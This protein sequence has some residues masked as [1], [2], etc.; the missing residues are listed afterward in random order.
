MQAILLAAGEGSR[1]RPYTSD[2]PKPMVRAGNQPIAQ[3]AVEALVA[4]GVKDVCMVVGYQRAKVQSYFGD[5][6]RFGARISYAFQE[7]LS[8]TAAAVAAA[9][10]PQDDFLVLGVDNVVD[11]ELIKT[12]LGGAPGVVSVVVRRSDDPSTY[13]VVNIESDRVTAI[14]EKPAMPR[15]DWIS[16]GVYRLPRAFHP[17]IVSKVQDGALGM[18]DVLQRALKNGERIDAIKAQ[19]L[20]ADAVY[21]WDLLDVHAAILRQGRANGR[22]IA[23][24]HVDPSSLLEKDTVVGPGSYIGPGTCAGR[25]VVIHPNCVI[26]N[27]VIY[28]DVEIGPGSILKNTIIGEGSRLGPRVIAESGPC[29]IRT[30]RSW[31]ALD[32]FGAIIGED[33]RVG[34]AVLLRPGAF[35]GNN[36][37][38]GSGR[39]VQGTIEDG[40]NV[41]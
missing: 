9:P 37:R 7:V 41:M 20:W 32:E 11:S 26:E 6:N 19:G 18:T 15:S 13:G 1:L 29:E 36:V 30:A 31:H 38:V 40:A 5:G 16:T 22:A 4:N 25:N 12:A 27:T 3:Y 23:G 17:R 28:D 8:G 39:T 34:A 35:I 24:A 14:E 33:C 10:A 2:K 21:P